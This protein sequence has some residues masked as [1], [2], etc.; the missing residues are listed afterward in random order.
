MIKDIVRT[1]MYD[2]MKAKDKTRKDAYAF[3]LG[4][5]MAEEKGMQNQDNPNPVLKDAEAIV[6]IR[7]IVKQTKEAIAKATEKTPKT[8]K[9]AKAVTDFVAQREL[10]IALYSEFLP[11]EMS[12]L[13]IL[14][15]IKNTAAEITTPINKG[16]LMKNVMPKLKGKAD[17][18]L[19]ST[20]VEKYIAKI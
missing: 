11:K 4:Q 19:I 8:D 13:E 9:E 6:V 3:L 1:K 10:E 18:K 12:E 17:G 16:L 14:D 5:L 20:L 2:A 15:V 7:R